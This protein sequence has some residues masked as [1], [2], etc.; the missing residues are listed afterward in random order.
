MK[1]RREVSLDKLE[2]HQPQ[3]VLKSQDWMKS[4]RN[5]SQKSD[6]RINTELR[7]P[8]HLGIEQR[9]MKMQIEMERMAQRVREKSK[10]QGITEATKKIVSIK[11][12][13]S[14]SSN[15]TKH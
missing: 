9:N 4:L 1:L 11:K 10:L 7:G 8:W 2:M 13:R 5:H 3:M 12:H 14:D 6:K 15:P